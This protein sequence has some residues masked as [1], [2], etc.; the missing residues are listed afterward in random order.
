VK[1][2]LR[3]GVSVRLPAQWDRRQSQR[4]EKPP[5]S[6]AMEPSQPRQN[7]YVLAF[8]QLSAAL[9]QP[10]GIAADGFKVSPVETASRWQCHVV[11]IN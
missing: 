8:N 4:Q 5:E 11:P 7:Q 6:A 1:L 2:R 10:E 3:R 9:R